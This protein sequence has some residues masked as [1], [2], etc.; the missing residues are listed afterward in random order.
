[1][2]IITLAALMGVGDQSIFQKALKHGKLRL[3]EWM[4]AQQK[5]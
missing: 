2:N 1:V 3:P 4:A 5:R